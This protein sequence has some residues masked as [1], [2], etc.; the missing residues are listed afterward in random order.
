MFLSSLYVRGSGSQRTLISVPSNISMVVD[1]HYYSHF[2]MG[3]LG[4]RE[5]RQRDQLKGS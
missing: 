1:G 3:M 2:V 5:V 4:L